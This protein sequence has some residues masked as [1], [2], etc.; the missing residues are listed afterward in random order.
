[1]HSPSTLVCSELPFVVSID[2]RA[3]SAPLVGAGLGR[4][5][6]LTVDRAPF[7]TL[8]TLS[9]ESEAAG[10]DDAVVAIG[11]MA[12]LWCPNNV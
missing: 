1:M 6:A 3:S 12:K 7:D 8:L 5:S 10:A 11:A 2:D 4:C 9:S